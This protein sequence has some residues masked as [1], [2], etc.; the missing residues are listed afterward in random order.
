MVHVTQ[1]T[2]VENNLVELKAFVDVVRIKS[3]DFEN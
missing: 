2:T 1:K 3:A